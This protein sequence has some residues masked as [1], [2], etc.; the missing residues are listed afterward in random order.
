MSFFVTRTNFLSE[1]VFLSLNGRRRRD[2]LPC[3]RDRLCVV[4]YEK[5]NKATGIELE[6][7]ERKEL[8]EA[9]RRTR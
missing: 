6:P 7:G 1:T 5:F 3:Q 4:G 2:G 9:Q 8:V